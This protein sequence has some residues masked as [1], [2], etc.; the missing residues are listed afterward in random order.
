MDRLRESALAAKKYL[1]TLVKNHLPVISYMPLV[2]AQLLQNWV[3]LCSE[4]GLGKIISVIEPSLLL[5]LL[6][7]YFIAACLFLAP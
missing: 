7:A 2:Q 3:L 6:H 4:S 5:R 1:I